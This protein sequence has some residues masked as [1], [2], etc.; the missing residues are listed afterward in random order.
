MANQHAIAATCEAV[1]QLLRMSYQPDRFGGVELEFKTYLSQDF[2]TPMQAGVSLFLYRLQ[3]NGVYRHHPGRGG[4]A[5][6]PLE[7]HF[8]L[9]VWAKDATFQ[10]ALAGWMM[11][12]LEETPVLTTSLL[13]AV[14]GGA[15]R[16]EETVEVVQADLNVQDQ[17]HLQGRLTEQGYPLSVPYM[18]RIVHIDLEGRAAT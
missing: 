1:L 11:R 2:A 17:I 10:N 4:R 16:S 8:L 3:P 18:A 7:L 6:L 13:N 5:S 14:W 15:F 12:T 9:T